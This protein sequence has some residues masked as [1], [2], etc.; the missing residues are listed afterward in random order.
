VVGRLDCDSS[1]EDHRGFW[2]LNG[3]GLLSI[4][5]SDW[6]RLGGKWN[7]NCYGGDNENKLKVRRSWNCNTAAIQSLFNLLTKYDKHV[8][9]LIKFLKSSE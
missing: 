5:K 6:T 1:S 3:F 2:Q 4:Y 9:H 8:L 7:S